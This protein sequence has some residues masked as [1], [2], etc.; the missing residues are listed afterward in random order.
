[1]ATEI[2]RAK[3]MREMNAHSVTITM[4]DGSIFH[5][6]VNIGSCRRLSDFFGKCDS[7]PFVVMFNTTIGE[8]KEKNV[9]FINRN[10]IVSVEPNEIDDRRCFPGSIAFKGELK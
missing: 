8:N 5:G 6:Y 3:S 2:E 9:Y 7:G 10:H 1:M 4:R